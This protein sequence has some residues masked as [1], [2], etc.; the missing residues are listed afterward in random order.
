MVDKDTLVELVPH[1]VAMLALVFL[2]LELVRILAG[3]V[4]FW[5]ELLVIIA[6]VFAYRPVVLRL[7]VAPDRWEEQ[8]KR[9]Q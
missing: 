8:A 7:G 2:A 5:V 9:S 1:Y 3:P 6:V 4:G